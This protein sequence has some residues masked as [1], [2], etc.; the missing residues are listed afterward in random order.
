MP[1]ETPNVSSEEENDVNKDEMTAKEKEEEEWVT[2]RPLSPELQKRF[3]GYKNLAELP[4]EE[5]RK[6]M[7]EKGEEQERK[8]QEENEGRKEYFWRDKLQ[9]NIRD[10]LG[11]QDGEGL[12]NNDDEMAHIYFDKSLDKIRK[13]NLSSKWTGSLK[14]YI[15]TTGADFQLNVEERLKELGDK[16]TPEKVKDV[17]LEEYNRIR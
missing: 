16:A 7:R 1:F 14:D 17:V 9:N 11:W 4:P 5:F 6:L 3:P 8:R 12:L 15:P 10:V 2:L 13:E